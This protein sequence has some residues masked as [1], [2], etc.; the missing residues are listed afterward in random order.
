MSMQTNVSCGYGFSIENVTEEVL[1]AFILKHRDVFSKTEKEKEACNFA[2]ITA[3]KKAVEDELFFY[4]DDYEDD[5]SSYTGFGAAISNIMTRETGVGFTYKKI[6]REHYSEK[7]ILFP[8]CL[9]WQLNDKEKK[10]TE[11]SLREIMS[12]YVI[13]LNH[14][15]S[16]INCHSVEYLVKW[17]SNCENL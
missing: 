10:L 15:T 5:N 14:E 16:N 1:A 12:K 4:L 13:E 9:P 3:D 2:E 6:Q 17:C 7:Y 8:K 11:D